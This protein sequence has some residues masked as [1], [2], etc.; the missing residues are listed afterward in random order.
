MM[1]KVS[2]K[3]WVEYNG[4]GAN[5]STPKLWISAFAGNT[6]GGQLRDVVYGEGAHNLMYNQYLKQ[7]HGAN[8]WVNCPYGS[9]PRAIEQCFGIGVCT[10]DT[11]THAR[12]TNAVTKTNIWHNK[13]VSTHGWTNITHTNATKVNKS[14]TE[15][16]S[17][18]Q[19]SAN[20][21]SNTTTTGADTYYIV[22]EYTKGNASIN[23][24]IQAKTYKNL[25][26]AQSHFNSCIVKHP[27]NPAILYERS[28]KSAGQSYTMK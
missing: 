4:S 16:Q 21:T 10:A 12:H 27:Q 2:P 5:G 1:M 25:T 14:A 3:Q 18:S 23:A 7:N 28:R 6:T 8:V 24:S 19:S 9:S 22:T 13:T 11:V 17:S 20:K 26:N 15:T